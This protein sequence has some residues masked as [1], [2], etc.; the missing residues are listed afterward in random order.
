MISLIYFFLKQYFFIVIFI[1]IYINISL[2]IYIYIDI[3]FDR[4]NPLASSEGPM[5]R[6]QPQQKVDLPRG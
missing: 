5:G 1:D 4:E 3:F 2:S 6:T